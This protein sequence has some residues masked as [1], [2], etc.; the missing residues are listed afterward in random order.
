MMHRKEIYLDGLREAIIDLSKDSRSEFYSCTENLRVISMANIVLKL[1]DI[2]NV[3]N[4]ILI[5]PRT[6]YDK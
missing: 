5:Y 6:Q 3:S 2:Y 1:L 4:S